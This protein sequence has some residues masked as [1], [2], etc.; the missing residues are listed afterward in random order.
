MSR[1]LL[2]LACRGRGL[3]KALLQGRRLVYP[4]HFE[5]L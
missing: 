4:P 5:H 2:Q 1:S 3:P